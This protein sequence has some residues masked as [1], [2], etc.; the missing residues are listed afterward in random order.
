MS[1]NGDTKSV[2]QGWKWK[3]SITLRHML[4]HQSA[5]WSKVPYNLTIP[6]L[7]SCEFCIR[8]FEYNEDHPDHLILPINAPGTKCT[9]HYYSFGWL[10]AGCLRG[11]YSIH[12]GR[13]DATLE[14]VYQKILL[15]KLSSCIIE[16]GFY[17]FGNCHREK[18]HEMAR[19]VVQTDLKLGRMIQEQR[20]AKAMGEFDDS[21]EDFTGDMDELK[22]RSPM[23][24]SILVEFRNGIRGNEFVLDPRIWNSRDALD[25]NV[26]AAGGR[27][28]AKG[29]CYFYHELASGRILSKDVLD[30][31]TEAS[32]TEQTLGVLQGQTS[33]NE[34]GST[35]QL[36]QK[37][38][39]GL[40]YVLFKG[41]S[42]NKNI[43]QS[44][45]KNDDN[46]FVGH[47]GVGG[48]VGLFHKST[49]TAI[50]VM[51]NG[52]KSGSSSQ[53]IQEISEHF[54]W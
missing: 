13:E 2:A 21:N 8:G 9:Y 28:S 36:T 14:E 7:S 42:K 52:G 6:K 12:H 50:A 38:E 19:T 47:P 10:V 5:L 40:G 20:E 46:E 25:A 34:N 29:L 35:Q 51:L 49:K 48:S 11:A 43:I 15:P 39:F 53:I 32:N 4:T 41:A 1:N 24:L 22:K 27:F 44:L 3:R 33:F 30:V 45:F 31:A 37:T 17:P 54:G 23:D 26:P 16:S 18:K